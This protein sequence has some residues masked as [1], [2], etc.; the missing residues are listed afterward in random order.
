MLE[1]FLILCAH[2]A[3]DDDNG[4]EDDNDSLVEESVWNSAEF[5]N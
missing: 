2:A 5:C 4:E 3:F 1:G